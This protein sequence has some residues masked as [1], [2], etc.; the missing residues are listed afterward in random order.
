M[1]FTGMSTER[2][3]NIQWKKLFNFLQENNYLN[4]FKVVHVYEFFNNL[5]DKGYN[6]NSLK[7]I[8]SAIM[9]P[10]KYIFKDYDF[11]NDNKLQTLFMY[12]K[13]HEKKEKEYFPPW[14]VEK[15]LVYLQS[16]DFKKLSESD[17]WLQLKKELFIIFLAA[18]KRIE[19]FSD[20]RISGIKYYEDNSVLL[21]PHSNFQRK[22]HTY[23]FCPRDVKIIECTENS[24]LCPVK[25]LN[26]YLKITEELC[27]NGNKVRSDYL[28]LNTKLEKATK[29]TLRAWIRKIIMLGDKDA[30]KKAT[31]F[32]SI[33]GIAATILYKNFTLQKVVEKMQW[34]NSQTFKR[35]YYRAGVEMPSQGVI[36]GCSI[37]N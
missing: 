31:N 14:S 35:Y 17:K 10:L 21:R 22:N 15:V 3:Y 28:W 5:I 26:N 2:Q 7:G 20:F 9:K 6:Y 37:T 11:I 23:D 19:E 13:T 4:N 30:N 25:A 8:R 34:K 32:H 36:A 1:H 24:K 18:P 12:V 16:E 33:R 27:K 29:N